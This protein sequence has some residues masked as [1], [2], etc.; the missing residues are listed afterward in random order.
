MMWT[1][2]VYYSSL[3]YF[4]NI[5]HYNFVPASS[6]AKSGA[7]QHIGNENHAA[8]NN[9]VREIARA[10]AERLEPKK[11]ISPA[12]EKELLMLAFTRFVSWNKIVFYQEP[13]LVPILLWDMQF[14]TIFRTRMTYISQLTK[15]IWWN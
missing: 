2:R 4:T 15:Y 5:K 13:Y 6:W 1:K 12:Y 10:A 7:W 11:K 8:A 9:E 14:F 3:H